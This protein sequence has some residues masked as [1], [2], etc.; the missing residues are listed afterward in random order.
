[1]FSCKY[2]ASSNRRQPQ[3][4]TNNCGYI[5]YYII[6]TYYLDV[7][8]DIGTDLSAAGQ[9]V[10]ESLANTL[11][12]FHPQVYVYLTPELSMV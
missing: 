1:M 5:V 6:S 2:S 7:L 8:Q 11:T 4:S 10:L 9:E 3:T 12:A